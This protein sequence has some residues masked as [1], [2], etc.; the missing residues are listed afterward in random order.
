MEVEEWPYECPSCKVSIPNQV[1]LI[2]HKNGKKHQLKVGTLKL[3]RC[4]LQRI[5]MTFLFV[6]QKYA[7]YARRLEESS[8]TVFISGPILKQ[9][10]VAPLLIQH[11]LE[12]NFGVVEKV[13]IQV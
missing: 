11:Y 12:E 10:S 2:A 4:K 9:P 1:S 8:R 13:V 3:F 5:S 7:E 6:L